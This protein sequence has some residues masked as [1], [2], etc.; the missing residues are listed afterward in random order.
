MK[1][2]SEQA[3]YKSGNL[4]KLDQSPYVSVQRSEIYAILMVFLGFPET[5]NINN[6]SQYAERV[7]LHNKTTEYIPYD[8]ELTSL[9]I[10]LQ[11]IMRNRNHP[12]YIYNSIQMPYMFTSSSCTRQ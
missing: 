3:A 8:S 6:V 4:S 5:L 2:K 9:F 10:Q 12:I 7:V 11:E 1:T